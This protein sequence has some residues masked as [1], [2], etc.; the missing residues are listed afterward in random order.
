MILWYFRI[1]QWPPS[2]K[3]C[4]HGSAQPVQRDSFQNRMMSNLV[5]T[6]TS[7]LVGCSLCLFAYLFSLLSLLG[8]DPRRCWQNAFGSLDSYANMSLRQTEST[9]KRKHHISKPWGFFQVTL[10]FDRAPTAPAQVS[11]ASGHQIYSC[12]SETGSLW[13]WGFPK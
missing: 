11:K 2:Q 12:A 3:G 7:R 8:T 9:C 13:T 10:W 5:E 6:S 4:C 1:T